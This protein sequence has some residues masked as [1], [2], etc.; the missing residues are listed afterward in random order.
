MVAVLLGFC[1]A[2][3]PRNDEIALQHFFLAY[4]NAR[5]LF[6]F[7]FCCMQCFSSNK[8]LQ[9]IFFQITPP[10]PSKVKW[11]A[12]YLNTAYALHW[13]FVN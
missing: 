9:E 4:S 6:L 7:H 11:L 3:H 8:R 1:K 12:P 13:T 10:P 2:P 5:I